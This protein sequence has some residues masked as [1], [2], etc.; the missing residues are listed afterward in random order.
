MPSSSTVS[1]VSLVPCA[2]SWSETATGIS[3]AAH[4]LLRHEQDGDTEDVVGEGAEEQAAG[5]DLSRGVLALCG[6]SVHAYGV[7]H[8]RTHGKG[9]ER[10][11]EIG[12]AENVA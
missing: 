7:Y 5:L 12:R 3:G 10:V 4:L 2:A 8:H 11:D 1:H 6:R 9:D